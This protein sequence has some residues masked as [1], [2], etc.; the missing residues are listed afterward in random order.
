MAEHPPITPLNLPADVRAILIY[1]GSFDPITSAHVR[2]AV[3]ARASWRKD[4]WL[5]FVPAARS[6]HRDMPSA[7]AEHRS[8]MVRLAITDI[9]A[10]T[11][12]TDEIDR[13]SWRLARGLDLPSYMSE[14]LERLDRVVHPD[15][16][17]RLLMGSDQA[18]AF[19]RWHEHRRVL[20]LAEP[21]VFV[22]APHRD[23]HTVVAALRATGAWTEPELAQ[24][25][26]RIVPCTPVE[27]SATEVRSGKRELLTEAVAEYIR[28]HGLYAGG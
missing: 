27:G 13:S 7:S 2:V 12:W 1:G 8:A 16:I 6:P 10:A 15:V 26:M 9:D 3:E 24:W 5:V 25:G 14:T 22:R 23:P 19:H 11:I 20:A 17:R 28:R 4:A 18:I 21:V